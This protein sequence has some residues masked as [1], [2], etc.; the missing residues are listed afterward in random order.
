VFEEGEGLGQK[1]W[2]SEP[3]MDA[4]EMV[5]RERWERRGEAPGQ[6]KMSKEAAIK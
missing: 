3:N 6:R 5:E 4:R 2:L 1:A